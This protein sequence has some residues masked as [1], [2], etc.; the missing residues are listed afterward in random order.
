MTRTDGG[1]GRA[2]CDGGGGPATTGD[3]LGGGGGGGGVV[4]PRTGIFIVSNRRP[5]AGN[6]PMAWM[7]GRSAGTYHHFHLGAHLEL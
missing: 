1:G 6:Q 7:G 3:G 2:S 5:G 4:K